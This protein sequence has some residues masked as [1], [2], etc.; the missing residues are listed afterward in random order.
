MK[1]P[2]RQ[3]LHLAAG[4][5]AAPAI[6]RIAGAQSRSTR[7]ITIIV[8]YAP[9]GASEAA[10]VLSGP[11]A[12]SLGQNVIVEHVSGGN[13]L[14]GTGRVARA[15]PDGYTLLVHNLAIAATVSLFPKA[16]FNVEKDLTAVGPSITAC[17]SSSAENPSR[18]ILLMNL[19][20]G[21]SNRVDT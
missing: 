6:S 9:G 1:L 3:F 12:A 16:T 4:A 17:R 2:R 13:A 18:Q 10:Q 15:S 11:L 7:P 19:L 8:P 20:P 21:S 14:I 5:V